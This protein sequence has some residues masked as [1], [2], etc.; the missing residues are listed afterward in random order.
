MKPKQCLISKSH[1]SRGASMIEFVIMAPL[2]LLVGLGVVQTGQVFHGKS[3][4][5]FALQEAA[6]MGA[7]SNG[8]IGKI[9]QGFVRGLVPYMGGS[10]SRVN[11]E[12]RQAEVARDLLVGAGSGWMRLRQLSPSQESFSDWAE[13]SFDE[14]GNAVREIPNANLAMLRCAPP[15][16]LPA[17]GTAGVKAST[18]CSGGEPIGAASQQTLADANLLKL[19][20]TYG[21][22]MGIPV[23]NR[24][25]GGALAMAKGCRTPEAQRVGALNLGTPQVV[26]GNPAECAHYLAR[27]E[28]GNWAPRMPV[29]L[30]VTVRMQTPA[31]FPGNQAW[32]TVASRSQDANTSG[33]QLGLGDVDAASRFA[34]IPVATLNPTGVTAA[35]DSRSRL[36]GDGATFLGY[37]RT[38]PSGPPE[39]GVNVCCGPPGLSPVGDSPFGP[40]QPTLPSSPIPTS[41]QL[42]DSGAPEMTLDDRSS[43][44]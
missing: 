12:T 23:V 33:R 4:L 15:S 17:G 26:V 5:N 8:D 2:L 13:N 41:I 25:V 44:R 37:Q 35:N 1:T 30:S 24:I 7:V 42:G 18:A 28:R 36:R 16:G 6:R 19:E 20:L 9:Q 10:T 11:F 29:N 32:F 38:R 21:V 22:R 40:R 34:P 27:D 31:R 43:R 14:S 3:A 39:C